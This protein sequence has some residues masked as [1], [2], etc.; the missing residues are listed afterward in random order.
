[1][2]Q[3]NSRGLLGLLVRGGTSMQLQDKYNSNVIQHALAFY[4]INIP[5][6]RSQFFFLNQFLSTSCKVVHAWLST[7]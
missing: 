1:M 5:G 7:V 6:A 3:Q 4:E 2:T